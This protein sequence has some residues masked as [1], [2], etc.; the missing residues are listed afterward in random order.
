MPK[1]IKDW[2]E[3]K[4]CSQMSKTHYLEIDEYSGHIYSREDDDLS[5]YLSTH[6]FYES[7]Y[8]SSSK[9]LQECGFDVELESWG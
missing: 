7:N 9:T 3:L 8:K 5:V 6:T 4:E 1:L 2:N